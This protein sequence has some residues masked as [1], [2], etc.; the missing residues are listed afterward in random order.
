[1]LLPP[2]ALNHRLSVS[3]YYHIRPV[4]PQ[5]LRMTSSRRPAQSVICSLLLLLLF[6]TWGY[7]H[8]QPQ[9]RV[10]NIDTSGYPTI[11]GDFLALDSLGKQIQG[12]TAADIHVVEN[13]I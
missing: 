9:L 1:M 10:F 3:L 13:D 2:V 6:T 4:S 11:R 8:A 12:L 7:L 5:E